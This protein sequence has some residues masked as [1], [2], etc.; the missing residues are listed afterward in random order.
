M[1]Y[2]SPVHAIALLLLAVGAA[3]HGFVTDPRMR[4]AI[5]TQRASGS[6]ADEDVVGQRGWSYCPHCLNV[7]ITG[8]EDL[9]RRGCLR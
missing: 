1:L 4:G 7:R 3:G 6:L 2:C 8:A 5:K 9:T